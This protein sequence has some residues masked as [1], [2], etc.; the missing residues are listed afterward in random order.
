MKNLE[1][2][3]HTLK[4]VIDILDLGDNIVQAVEE[5]SMRGK[6]GRDIEKWDRASEKIR[7]TLKK[8]GVTHG[9]Y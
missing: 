5:S 7:R 9:S 6:C 8:I 2:N 4:E 1:L 3:I